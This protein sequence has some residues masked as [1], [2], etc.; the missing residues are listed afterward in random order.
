[1]TTP[2]TAWLDQAAC[3][4]IADPDIFFP[5]R[6]GDA[7]SRWGRARRICASC[8]VTTECLG[9]AL[10]EEGGLLARYRDG[11]RGGL[12]PQQRADLDDISAEEA[13]R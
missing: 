3:S 9:A 13:A 7:A 4:G 12:T 5:R 2:G 10:R 8:P 1:M 11:M 6:G